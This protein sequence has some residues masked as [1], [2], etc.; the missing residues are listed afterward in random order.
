VVKG[1]GIEPDTSIERHLY[2]K[3]TREFQCAN[4]RLVR[5]LRLISSNLLHRQFKF[6]LFKIKFVTYS[7]TQYQLRLANCH[8]FSSVD[9]IAKALSMYNSESFHV[10][11]AVCR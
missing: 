6:G 7:R 2:I 9:D 5:Y 11:R 4:C 3:K 1:N 10:L 8:F